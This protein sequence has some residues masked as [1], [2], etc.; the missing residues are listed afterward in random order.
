MGDIAE[1]CEQS[2]FDEWCGVDG[3]EREGH[4]YGWYGG[5]SYEPPAPGYSA[6]YVA[7]A[8]PDDFPLIPNV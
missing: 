4:Y 6:P 1:M 8:R 3:H 7:K 2:A 5:R